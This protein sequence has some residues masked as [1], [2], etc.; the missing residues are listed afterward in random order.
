MP[1]TG[2]ARRGYDASGRRAQARANRE[3]VL[4]TARRLFIEQ[5]YAGTSIAQIAAAAG[6]SG[7]TVFAGF[8]SKANLLKE[9]IDTAIVGDL[10]PVPLAERTDMR[11]V[12]AARTAAEVIRRYTALIRE[13][14]PRACPIALVVYAAADADPE[15]AALARTID[16]QRLRGAEAIARTLVARLGTPDRLGEVRDTV[17]TLISPLQYG[18]LVDQRGWSV[19][20]YAD[21][22]GRALAALA[23]SGMTAT[24]G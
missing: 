3:R 6:V 10:E 23:A 12:H 7:P 5:G 22:V 15:I 2:Q 20:R 14:A 24:P 21:W 19:E 1:S 17:W 8:R 9:A 16:E 18:L 11:E 13:I 4:D